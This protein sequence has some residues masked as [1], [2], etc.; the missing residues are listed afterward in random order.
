MLE[1]EWIDVGSVEELKPKPLQEVLC[2]TT[3][4]ALSYKDGTFA[5]ISGVCNHAG[6]VAPHRGLRPA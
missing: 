3:P 2:E 5:A 4:I 6:G 1:S